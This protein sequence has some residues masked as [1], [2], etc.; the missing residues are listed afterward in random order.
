ME[1]WKLCL[2]LFNL[3]IC[4]IIATR[5]KARIIHAARET[6]DDS[7]TRIMD[8]EKVAKDYAELK[9]LLND[10]VANFE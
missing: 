7:E 3:K 9:D 4:H 8:N 1:G 10:A 5:C 2:R 6:I